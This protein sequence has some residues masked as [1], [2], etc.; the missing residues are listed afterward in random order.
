[1]NSQSATAVLAPP[2]YKHACHWLY[3]LAYNEGLT[4]QEIMA[5]SLSYMKWLTENQ[6]LHAWHTGRIR[7]PKDRSITAVGSY[8]HTD[9]LEF[10]T[11]LFFEH[12][13]D[14]TAFRL[15]WGML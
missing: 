5:C 12:P 11:I 2:L 6:V 8:S 14:L 7:V 1:M 10:S 3:H 15:R 9:Y 4:G 13:S